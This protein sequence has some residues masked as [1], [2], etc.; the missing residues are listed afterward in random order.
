MKRVKT[1]LDHG[2]RFMRKNAFALSLGACL[3]LVGTG[4]YFARTRLSTPSAPVPQP[5]PAPAAS[6]L[7]ERLQDKPPKVSLLW[8]IS[9][10]VILTPNSPTEPTWSDTLSQWQTHEGIDIEATRGE[11]VHAAIAGTVTRAERDHLMGHTVEVTSED[12]ILTRYQNLATSSLVKV[13]D[14]V[15][16]GDAI[17]AVGD[18]SAL[19]GGQAAHLHFEAWQNGEWIE[20]SE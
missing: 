10:R 2:A 7:D 8:P 19:E 11:V 13:G 12:G 9:G 5:L 1:W 4:L 16:A 15:K 17:G 18:S 3:L 14:C 6:S 20:L